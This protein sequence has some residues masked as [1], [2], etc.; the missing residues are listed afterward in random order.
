[1]NPPRIEELVGPPPRTLDEE[2]IIAHFLGRTAG[3]IRQHLP[4]S[5]HYQEDFMWMGPAGLAYY[6]PVVFDYLQS[7]ESSHDIQLS[8]GLLG[9]LS[10]QV[11]H[12]ALP[13]SLLSLVRAI[14]KYVNTHRTKFDLEATEPLLEGYLTK[15]RVKTGGLPP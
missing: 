3:E 14:A 6:L 4:T 2:S 11:E 15:I 9:S 10:F 1:M 13:E 5:G 12:C 8:H 7:D